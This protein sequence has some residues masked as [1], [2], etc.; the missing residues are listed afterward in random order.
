MKKCHIAYLACTA[1]LLGTG[2]GAA[3]PATGR[4][5]HRVHVVHPGQSIQRAV[6]AAAPG[7]TVLVAFGTYRESVTV[8]TPGL[9]LRG[10]GRGTV[11]RPAAAPA[12]A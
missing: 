6:D 7:D 4:P 5:A 1:T 11:L 9:T 12:G 2:L 3:S 8:K 10:M